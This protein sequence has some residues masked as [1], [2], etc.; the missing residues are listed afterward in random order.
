[1][2]TII[3]ISSKAGQLGNRLFNFTNFIAFAAEHGMTVI[4][5]SFDEY[6]EL[7]ELTQRDLLCRYPAK[8]FFS[9][10][11]ANV[12]M[13]SLLF[14]LVSLFMRII[15]KM[16]FWKRLANVISVSDHHLFLL[17]DNPKAIDVFRNSKVIFVSGLQFRD[18]TSIT[19]H[20]DEI[21]DY[22]RPA[23]KYEKA[24]ELLIMNIRQ[25][26]EVLIGVHIRRGDYAN[27]LGGRYYFEVKDYVRIIDE[28]KAL[29]PGKRIGYLICS[30]ENL[31]RNHFKDINCFFGT[32]HFLEDMYSLAGCDY[33]VGPPS[34]FS[35]WASFYGQA[36][37]CFLQKPDESLT[38]ENFVD[39]YS[40]F[41]GKIVHQDQ[42]GEQY[43][44][45][46]GARYGL[47][48]PTEKSQLAL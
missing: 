29:F 36:L 10:R 21:R 9:K 31:N 6:A 19:K 13:R 32:G 33:I 46:N 27:H 17:D 48:F 12:K 7:F 23:R 45:I 40:H 47:V 24:V 43:L 41:A 20:G 15:K 25:N 30:N 22:F 42:N 39:Y 18:I 26:C 1:L 11:L 34:T 38:L 37:L 5:P 8:R 28:L 3:V 35:L 2:R 44:L 14:R 16:G 4:N